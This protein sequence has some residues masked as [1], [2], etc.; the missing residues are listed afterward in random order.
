M[1]F[2]CIVKIQVSLLPIKKWWYS[3]YY[4][5]RQIID[6]YYEILSNSNQIAI[7]YK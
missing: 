3:I 2:N 4:P 6:N 7:K 1:Y 5:A